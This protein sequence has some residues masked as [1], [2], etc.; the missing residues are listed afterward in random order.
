[1]E[2]LLFVRRRACA[3]GV[4]PLVE[5]LVQSGADVNCTNSFGYSCLLEAC[6]RGYINVAKSLMT[7]PLPVDFKYIPTEEEAANSPFS[8]APCQSALAEA[9]RCGFYKVVQVRAMR[10]S[11]HDVMRCCDYQTPLVIKILFI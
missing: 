9:A 8:G 2:I 7:G 4:E 11:S 6:H 1:M 10:P 5:K 3:Y